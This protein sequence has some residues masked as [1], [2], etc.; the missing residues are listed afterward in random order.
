M[1]MTKK[2]TAPQPSDPPHVAK[3][4]EEN[5][6]LRLQKEIAEAAAQRSNTRVEGLLETLA[7]ERA[8][9]S[10]HPSNITRNLADAV[11]CLAEEHGDRVQQIDVTHYPDG[12]LSRIMISRFPVQGEQP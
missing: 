12:Q 1:T 8:D 9:R 5:A 3:L 4:R 7:K 6:Q 11:A 2:T 10:N